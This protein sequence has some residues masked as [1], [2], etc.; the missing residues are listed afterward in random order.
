MVSEDKLFELFINPESP[1][2]VGTNP[3]LFN[4]EENMDNTPC[5][6]GFGTLCITPTLDLN[7]CVSLPMAVAN[8]NIIS[9]KN[10]WMDA[11]HHNP[12]SKLYQW[13]AV[14][15]SDLTECYKEDYC[16]FCHYCAGMGYLENGYL[17]KSDILCKQAKAKQR[18]FNYLKDQN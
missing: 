2:Y 7:I 5:L 13:Q 17:K 11:I 14:T 4:I 6:G 18:A 9:I 8:L 12:E 3:P 16:K 15:N 1:L 10:V